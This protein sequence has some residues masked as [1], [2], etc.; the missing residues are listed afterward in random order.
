MAEKKRQ[1]STM[2]LEETADYLGISPEELMTS[3][4]R[5]MEPGRSG[6]KKDGVLVWDRKTLPKPGPADAVEEE[7]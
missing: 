2:T 4:G 7:T 5:G 6:Y 1:P 3:R